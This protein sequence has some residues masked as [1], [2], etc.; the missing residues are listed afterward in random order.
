MEVSREPREIKTITLIAFKEFDT[1]HLA[2]PHD[3]MLVITLDIATFEVSKVLI[4]NGSLVDP[5]F[6]S[7]L[8]RADIVGP[9]TLL[10]CFTS[11]ISMS[12]G[13]IRLL[14]L[15][16]GVSKI[17]EFTVFDRPAAYNVILGTSWI[18]QMKAVPSMY[19]QCVKFPTPNGVGNVKG[20]QK[21]S[22]SCYLISHRLKIQ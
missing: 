16:A 6:L 5:I 13:T 1:Q 11:E 12:L 10:I 21:M 19:H 22:R 18:Y 2:K 3:D 7:T 20:D 8:Q 15:V 17:V 9:P 14:V 4:D